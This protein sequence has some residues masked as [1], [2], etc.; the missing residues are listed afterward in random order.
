MGYS[1]T[2][3]ALRAG[4]NPSVA[5]RCYSGKVVEI[6]RE[7]ARAVAAL[8]SPADASRTNRPPTTARLRVS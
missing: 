7:L 6:D 8:L 3:V 5:A 1:G 4:H 2:Q